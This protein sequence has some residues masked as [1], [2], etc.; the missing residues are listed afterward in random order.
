MRT[1]L[2]PK[3]LVAIGDPLRTL[4]RTKNETLGKCFKDENFTN[5]LDGMTEQGVPAVGIAYCWYVDREE[6][7]QGAKQ[8]ESEKESL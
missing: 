3:I 1:L 7:W 6:E 2:L 8:K 4:S 5:G